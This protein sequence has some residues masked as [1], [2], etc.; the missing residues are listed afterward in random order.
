MNGKAFFE[1]HV[2]TTDFNNLSGRVTKLNKLA[3]E[4]WTLVTTVTYEGRVGSYPV[5]VDTLAR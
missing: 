5:F 1:Y 2:M 4:N 3:E